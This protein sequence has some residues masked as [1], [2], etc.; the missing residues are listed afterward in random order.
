MVYLD[1]VISLLDKH[2]SISANWDLADFEKRIRERD[3]SNHLVK[4]SVNKPNADRLY[5]EPVPHGLFKPLF[6]E[7]EEEE[8]D[9]SMEDVV[10]TNLEQLELPDAHHIAFKVDA[11]IPAIEAP[12]TAPL[13]RLN[14]AEYRRRRTEQLESANSE[15]FNALMRASME[16]DNIVANNHTSNATVQQL[17]PPQQQ[18]VVNKISAPAPVPA[19]IPAPTVTPATTNTKPIVSVPFAN[20]Y[21]ASLMDSNIFTEK[22][23]PKIYAYPTQIIPIFASPTQQEECA[24]DAIKDIRFLKV[25][26]TETLNALSLSGLH[27]LEE[28]GKGLFLIKLIEKLQDRDLTLALVTPTFNE[29]SLLVETAQR[30]GL[31]C[32]RFSNILDD[33]NSDYGVYLEMKIPNNADFSQ[34]NFKPADFVICLGAALNRSTVDKVKAAPETPVAWM[35][36]LGSAEERLYNFMAQENVRYPDCTDAD[37]FQNLLLAS[38][39]WPSYDHYSFQEL[40]SRV[41]DNVSC[42]LNLLGRSKYQFRSTED[43]P[44]SYHLAT[45]KPQTD[46]DIEDMDISSSDTEAIQVQQD[47]FPTFEIVER[48]PTTVAPDNDKSLVDDYT[49]EAKALKNKFEGEYKALLSKYRTKLSESHKQM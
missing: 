18:P 6:F 36:T 42:W 37:G 13:I 21:D 31:R 33:W 12:A 32:V 46:G 1:E 23:G 27:Q 25:N 19:P 15:Q 10:S 45:F 35:V 44:L 26:F 4:T 7:E 3:H 30:I 24:N 47:I 5:L 17:R 34:Y 40:T 48:P 9:D 2:K 41:A 49:S 8:E 14:M 43:L 29:E 16:P 38:N 22:S 39:N 20:L 28:V 11:S